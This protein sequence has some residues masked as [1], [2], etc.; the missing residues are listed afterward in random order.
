MFAKRTEPV[1]FGTAKRYATGAAAICKRVENFGHVSRAPFYSSMR[2][3]TILLGVVL[4]AIAGAVIYSATRSD[5]AT[6]DGQGTTMSTKRAEELVQ[7]E[8]ELDSRFAR[9]VHS[10]SRHVFFHHSY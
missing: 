3:N 2:P 5:T 9:Y 4:G 10:F 8:S 1:G 6:D 7:G